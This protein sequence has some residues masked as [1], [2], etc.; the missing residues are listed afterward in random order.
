MNKNAKKLQNFK[1]TFVIQPHKDWKGC[2][3]SNSVVFVD[4]ALAH[5]MFK[6]EHANFRR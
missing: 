6:R 1:N 3:N 4:P 2:K 5:M